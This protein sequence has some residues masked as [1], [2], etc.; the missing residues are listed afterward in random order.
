M[1][2]GNLLFGGKGESG[3]IFV[4]SLADAAAGESDLWS[5]GI[6]FPG[7]AVEAGPGDTILAVAPDKDEHH[8]LAD[9]REP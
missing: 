5:T 7:G 1:K 2:V 3:V 4:T 8:P 9:L 6:K